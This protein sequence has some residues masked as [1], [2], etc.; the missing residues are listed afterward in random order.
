MK[1]E[2]IGLPAL[3]LPERGE[4]RGVRERAGAERFSID[5]IAGADRPGADDAHPLVADRLA[6]RRR[7]MA[8]AVRRMDGPHAVREVPTE[9]ARAAERTE[10]HA[11]LDPADPDEDPAPGEQAAEEE[12]AAAAADFEALS[13]H[14]LRLGGPIREVTL[15]LPSLGQ[16]SARLEA[17]AISIFL[18]VPRRLVAAV[19]RG[20]R[21]LR[22][23]MSR[24]GLRIAQIQIREHDEPGG[25]PEAPLRYVAAHGLVDVMA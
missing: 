1:V 25:K 7:G 15:Y 16:V 10:F 21:E 14:L 6:T 23:Q 13:A 5:G 11:G 4:L 17:G 24:L 20:E 9:E 2:G 8:R 19:R 22:A 18:N 12:Q 3:S